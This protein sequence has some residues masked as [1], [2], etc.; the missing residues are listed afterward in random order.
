LNLVKCSFG[1][2]SRKLLG[3]VVSRKCIEVNLDKVKAIQIMLTNK[4]EKEVKV[5]LGRW[6]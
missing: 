4:T 2:K 5:F 3:F 1:I 6:N